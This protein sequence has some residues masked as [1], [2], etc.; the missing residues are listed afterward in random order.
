MENKKEENG[1]QNLWKKEDLMAAQNHAV[2]EKSC[3]WSDLKAHYIL[4]KYLK[5]NFIIQMG[6]SASVR[7]IQ[8]FDTKKNLNYFGNRGVSGIEGSTSTAIGSASV[9]S[10]TNILITGDLS[11]IYDQNGLWNNHIPNN[12]KLFVFNN[13]GGGIFKIISGPKNTPFLEQYFE[14]KH[15]LSLKNIAHTHHLNY[16]CAKNEKEAEQIIPTVLNSNQFEIV[17]FFTG[18][19][20]NEKILNDY[21]SVIKK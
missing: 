21:F 10:K 15:E 19:V 14:T 18:N 17:E 11:F 7:Y 8:L 12:L 9:H 4:Q 16:H 2:F 13:Q 5:D 3:I 1:F 20:E 6:N